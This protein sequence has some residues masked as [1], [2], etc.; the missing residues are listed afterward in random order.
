MLLQVFV[1]LSWC[2]EWTSVTALFT[3][4]TY[5]EQVHGERKLEQRDYLLFSCAGAFNVILTR[6]LVSKLWLAGHGLQRVMQPFRMNK[7]AAMSPSH[8]WAFVVVWLRVGTQK[9]QAKRENG[10]KEAEEHENKTETKQKLVSQSSLY[11]I[12]FM[13]TFIIKRIP[14]ASL[15]HPK[16]SEQNRTSDD[17][18]RKR[19]QRPAVRKWNWGKYTSRFPYALLWVHQRLVSY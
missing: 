8:V 17:K 10:R 4:A 13:R 3:Y 1:L 18:K 19:K 9:I 16:S 7:R 6:P 11:E 12:S 2:R 5:P 15:G 14:T